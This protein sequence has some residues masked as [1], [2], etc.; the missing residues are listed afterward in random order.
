MWWVFIPII[1]LDKIYLRI[2]NRETYFLDCTRLN[3]SSLLVSRNNP[4]NMYSVDNG[5][6]VLSNYLKEIGAKEI[7]LADDVVFSGNVLKTIIDKFNNNG[8]SVIGITSSVATKES[9]EYFNKNLVLGLKTGFL[10]EKKVI[11]QICE[12]DFYY[13]IAQS[14]I[15][16]LENNKV[17]KAPYFIPFGN[18][19]ERAS[20]PK[21]KELDFSL[22]CI[23]RSK[24]LW[25][26]IYKLS[27][28]EIYNYDLPEKITF[29]DDK[30]IV[31]ETL[32]KG[33]YELCKS[34]K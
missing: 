26:E 8:I 2:N 23:K 30:D 12:R 6:K 28:K 5:I 25:E 13:G 18:P 1:S 7:I 16:V 19:Y 27:N 29:S 32:E 20:I 34:F 33:E 22:S 21:E 10:L 15:S 17:L 4:N 3:N 9:F 24:I 11:D 14:G 31:L